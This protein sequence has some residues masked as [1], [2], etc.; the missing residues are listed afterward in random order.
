MQESL[1]LFNDMVNHKNF[2]NMPFI[3][4]FNKKDLFEEKIKKKSIA[5]AFPN[6]Q[7][8]RDLSRFFDQ[9]GHQTTKKCIN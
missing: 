9:V 8:G 7:V 2:E 6:Y 4:F 5:V 3:V 1:R